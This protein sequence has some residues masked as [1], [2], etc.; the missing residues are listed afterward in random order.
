[1]LT[2]VVFAHWGPL[3]MCVVHS[4]AKLLGISGHNCGSIDIWQLIYNQMSSMMLRSGLILG[5]SNTSTAAQWMYSWDKRAV[6][7]VAPSYIS[8]GLPMRRWLPTWGSTWG[9]NF[10]DISLSIQ[11]PPNVNKV[12]FTFI[13]DASPHCHW[14][15]PW[16]KLWHDAVLL[17]AFTSLAPNTDP[18]IA[19]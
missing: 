17:I 18:A 1:M 16:C 12:Q 9:P 11:I 6:C 15:A 8:M 4:R 5:Q 10:I 2:L 3:A 19:F 14:Y 7:G 13:W